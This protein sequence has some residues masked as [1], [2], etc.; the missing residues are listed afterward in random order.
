MTSAAG[1]GTTTDVEGVAKGYPDDPVERTRAWTGLWV[2]VVGDLMIFGGALVAVLT[3]NSDGTAG[4][5]VVSV[6]S[7]AFATI[8]TMTT[9]YF[10]IK[11]ASSTAQS[12]L[13]NARLTLHPPA[14]PIAHAPATAPAS[15]SGPPSSGAQPPDDKGAPSS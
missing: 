2:V 1:R 8:G 10:G 14:T 15:S 13:N 12:S 9:A 4:T 11:S 6:M 5:A 7:S 3:L